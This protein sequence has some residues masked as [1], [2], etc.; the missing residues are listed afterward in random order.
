MLIVSKIVYADRHRSGNSKKDH[1]NQPIVCADIADQIRRGEHGIAGVTIESN[2]FAGAQK[3]PKDGPE[4]LKKGV[5]VTDACVDFPTTENVLRDL[6]QAV[7]TRRE[8]RSQRC[9]F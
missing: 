2:L 6:A 8:N 4:G 9:C 5:S 3:I 1:N 7:R